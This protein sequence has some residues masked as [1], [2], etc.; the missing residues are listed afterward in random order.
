MKRKVLIL[1]TLLVLSTGILGTFFALDHSGL[2]ARAAGATAP[3]H[4]KK[5][6]S[7]STTF[8]FTPATLTV[9]VGTTVTWKNSSTAAHT[10]TGTSFHS[11]V[12]APGRTF[13][14]T[15]TKAGTYS[16]HCIFHPYMKGTIVVH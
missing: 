8:Q 6:V 1:C 11:P 2:Q 9:T 16:Y 12:I 7:I 15:F 13:S 10:V 4:T 3:K 14:Y 5:T